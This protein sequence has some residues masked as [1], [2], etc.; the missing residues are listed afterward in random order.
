[1]QARG[2][3]VKKYKIFVDITNGSPLLQSLANVLL[4]SEIKRKDVRSAS[5]N[6]VPER[7]LMPSFIR[8]RLQSVHPI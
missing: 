2:E 8:H 7:I 6:G 1:M 3:G 5:V 4:R